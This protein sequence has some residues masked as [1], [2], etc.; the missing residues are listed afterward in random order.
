MVAEMMPVKFNESVAGFRGIL[1]DLRLPEKML[2]FMLSQNKLNLGNE[3]REG[4]VSTKASGLNQGAILMLIAS[5]AFIGYAVVFLLR[6]FSGS[7][8][9]LGVETLN[10]VTRA[11]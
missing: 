1:T 2:C 10:G 7:G 4:Q 6:N 9:E 5:L 11:N 3:Q 8:F